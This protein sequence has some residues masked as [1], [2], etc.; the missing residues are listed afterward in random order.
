MGPTVVSRF[1][2]KSCNF[3]VINNFVEILEIIIE[4]IV[5]NDDLKVRVFPACVAEQRIKTVG[6][7]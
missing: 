7:C 6:A 5:L 4:L 1:I 2:L 3:I